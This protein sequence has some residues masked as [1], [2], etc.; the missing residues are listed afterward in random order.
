M[1][2]VTGVLLALAGLPL[3]VAQETQDPP[4]AKD[5]P[6]E[7]Q[8]YFERRKDE[9]RIKPGEIPLSLFLAFAS[10]YASLP[11]IIADSG[12]DL[13]SGK[14]PVKE[15]IKVT[16]AGQVFSLLREGGIEV[17][18]V[19]LPNGKVFL[20]AS[21]LRPPRGPAL[22]FK[23]DDAPAPRGDQAP[24]PSSKPRDANRVSKGVFMTEGRIR[25]TDL[26]QFFAAF[27]GAEVF[28][29]GSI[30]DAVRRMEIVN[31]VDIPEVDDEIVKEML[32]CHGVRLRQVLKEDGATRWRVS[33]TTSSG[34]PRVIRSPG[35]ATDTKE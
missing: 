28:G 16:G 34:I 6:E 11:L 20:E 15:E 9:V 1:K 18:S 22:I 5:P 2:R 23:P 35:K 14:I 19:V 31:V 21:R 32:E 24:A 17:E 10:D 4:P 29:D 7:K 3:G 33:L 13:K 25:V 26:L 12:L 30:A 27:Q 8:V